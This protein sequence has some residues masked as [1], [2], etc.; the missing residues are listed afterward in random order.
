MNH[1]FSNGWPGGVSVYPSNGT[2]EKTDLYTLGDD[3]SD[4][5]DSDDDIGY[6]ENYSLQQ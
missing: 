5:S 1:L 6:I 4:Y 3:D 2:S